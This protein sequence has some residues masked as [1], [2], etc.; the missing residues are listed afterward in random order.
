MKTFFPKFHE[1]I[2]S[3]SCKITVRDHAK[4]DALDKFYQSLLLMM[5]M[6]LNA[7]ILNVIILI[8]RI[9][10]ENI[11]SENMQRH[12][13]GEYNEDMILVV[14]EYKVQRHLKNVKTTV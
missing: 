2:I 13:A 10:K 7:F 8:A 12:T 9:Q 6:T 11:I 5:M 14:I 1:I 4:K 3:T